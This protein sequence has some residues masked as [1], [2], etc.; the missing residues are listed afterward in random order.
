MPDPKSKKI[1]FAERPSAKSA[2]RGWH[3]LT[4][5][6][7]AAKL[8]VGKAGLSFA[9]AAERL[10]QYGYNELPEEPPI[11]AVI[12]FF[13][14]FASVLIYILLGAAAISFYLGDRVD[15]AVILAAILANVFVGFI[16]ALVFTTLTLIFLEI[17]G[18]EHGDHDQA[19]DA[20]EENMAVNAVA[21]PH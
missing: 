13:R 10:S 17:A 2:H 4:L 12:L 16:Q 3:N 11:R 20:P 21:L 6:E 18:A 5:A 7:T 9:Q 14:Q 8:K 1:D 19:R 15:A